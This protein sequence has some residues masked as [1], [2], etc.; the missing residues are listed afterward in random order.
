MLNI[1]KS[2]FGTKNDRELRKIAP[3]LTKINM[4][5][6]T[7]QALTDAELKA[8]TAEFKGR[9]QKGETLDSLLPEAFAV[10]REASKRSLG[11]R[12]FDVQLIGGSV[13]HQ[14]KIA[15]MRTGEGKTLT[16]TAPVYSNALT[17]KG[18][19]VVTVNEYLA[20]TQSQEMGRLYGFLGLTT[21]CIL[22]GMSDQERQEAYRCDV[23]YATNNLILVLCPD[24]TIF[25]FP[26]DIRGCMISSNQFTLNF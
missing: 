7:M 26:C 13:L 21:G 1:L 16:A 12:H 6:A 23:T 9:Y 24:H 20:S 2:L 18:V 11:K 22:N 5:E 17:G 14:G 25:V 3:I 4:L 19:H 10:V 8:K 15:E